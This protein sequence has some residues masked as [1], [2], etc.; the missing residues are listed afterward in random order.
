MQMETNT[1]L[2]SQGRST[3]RSRRVILFLSGLVLGIGSAFALA[4]AAHAQSK[5]AGESMGEIGNKLAN[6]LADLWALSTSINAPQYFDGDVNAGDPELGG[7]MV[8][9]PVMPIPLFGEGEDQWRMITRPVIPIIFSQPVPEG[10]NRFSDEGGIGD[11]QLPLLLAPSDKL[12]G[13]FILGGG[14]IFQF[15][16]ATH[17]DLGLNQWG[18]GPAVVL[19]YKTEK[20]TFGV[21]PNY[22]WK[23]GSA[24]QGS[25]PDMNRLSLLYFFN[26]ALP[27]AW[28]FGFNPTISYNDRATTGNRW[29][30]PIGFY[31]GR[32]IKAGKLPVNI[33]VGGE[34]S[35]VSQDFFGQRFQFRVQ[36]TPVIP[37][38]V[39]NPVLAS[40]LGK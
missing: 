7:L 4:S 31:V 21:F 29:N 8:F 32:T 40:I 5:P 16:S 25:T 28:Q 39:K 11:I 9:Q 2:G 36:I 17:N 12:S 33:K 20:A 1:A 30:V 6:P 22:F 23:I 37:S 10:Q 19:G 27:E 26:Y 18:M 15:P 14:P 13:H 24:G 38:L 34:Y 35:V 3:R